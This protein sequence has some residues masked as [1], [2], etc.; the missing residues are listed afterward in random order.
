[1]SAIL[2]QDGHRYVDVGVML[3]ACKHPHFVANA[4]CLMKVGIEKNETLE[5]VISHVLANFVLDVSGMSAGVR[6]SDQETA[7]I[8]RSLRQR[9]QEGA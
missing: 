4:G 2:I 9:I 6:F 5:S 1:M 3:A 7:D 8:M